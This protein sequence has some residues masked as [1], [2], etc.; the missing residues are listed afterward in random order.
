MNLRSS[1]LQQLEK[2]HLNLDQQTELRCQI[3]KD[4]EEVGDYEGA[5]EA[6]G[7]LWRG[8]GERPK[9]R[10]LVMNTAAEV[11][12][13]AGTLTGWLGSCKQIEAAQ[14]S[15]KNLISE[16]VRIFESFSYTKK[17]LE[18]QTELAYCYWRQ[19]GYDEAR[20]ILKGVLEQL[21]KDNE[22]RAK[23]ILRSAIVERGA[24]RYND[25]L[26]IL[27]DNARLFQKITSHSI[28]G[29]YHN[30]L[31]IVLRNLGAF[32]MREDYLD[33]AFVEYAAASYH[34]EQAGHIPY[35]ALVENNLGFIFFKSNRFKEAHEHLDRARRLFSTLKDKGSVAQVDDTRARALLAE[36]RN[37]EAEK[38]AR[39]SVRVLEKG[40]HQSLL[41]EALTTYGVALARLGNYTQARLMLFRAMEVGHISGALNRAGEAALTLIKELGKQLTSDEMQT[42][43]QR[44]YSWL[45]DTQDKK[46]LSRLLEAANTLMDVRRNKKVENVNLLRSENRL[47]ERVQS[48]E[49]QLIR[50]ALKEAKGSITHAARLLGITH[51]RLNYLIQ[52][53]H[54]E[55]GTE[56]KPIIKRKP[57]VFKKK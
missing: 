40:G 9:I 21:T 51:Q 16:S 53:R 42:A 50:Q 18:A 24:Y 22:L 30:E 2:P 48:Y 56:R 27:T 46:T 47:T 36:G 25:A 45:T 52:R 12:L 41:A 7:G 33:R 57:R 26:R 38:V 15:A 13:R 34:F 19:G 32:E 55:L 20:I 37:A 5:R 23:A 14:E 3:A 6:L 39:A 11:I 43:Y 31:A 10:G 49:R 8:I 1:L 17:V 35:C 44:A 54:K 28:K 4:L 29:G